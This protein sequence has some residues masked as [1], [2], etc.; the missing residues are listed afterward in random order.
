MSLSETTAL[1]SGGG[2]TTEFTVLHGWLTDP[3]H[4]GITTDGL[5]AGVDKDDFKVLVDGVLVNPVAV[6]DT[7]IGAATTNTLFS[8]GLEV[9]GGLEL[10]HTMAGWLTHDGSLADLALATTTTDTDAVDDTS[11][12]GLVSETTGLVWARGARGTVDDVELTEL[13]AADAEDETE[14]IGL[15]LLVQFFNVFVG[16]HYLKGNKMDG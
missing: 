12:L 6:Q 5:V 2:K 11:L 14:D 13:P 4:A 15:L 10:V 3:V 16:T 9:T 7:E 1:L 8:D